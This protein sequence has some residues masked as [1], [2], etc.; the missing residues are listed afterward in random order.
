[1]NRLIALKHKQNDSLISNE[2]H[3]GYETANDE[4]MGSASASMYFS[5]NESD[6]S[7]DKTIE[8]EPAPQGTQMDAGKM[9]QRVLLVPLSDSTN[10]LLSPKRGIIN[11]NRSFT[12]SQ[13]S[14]ST[15]LK[16]TNDVEANADLDGIDEEEENSPNK[17]SFVTARKVIPKQISA[18]ITDVH[19]TDMVDVSSLPI[20]T[21]IKAASKTPT[22]EI[23]GIALMD[24]S[25]AT[26][27]E[28]TGAKT[29]DS[30]AIL[31]A[32]IALPESIT[33]PDAKPT[34]SLLKTNTK[35][36][37]VEVVPEKKPP[38]TRRSSLSAAFRRS[39]WAGAGAGLSTI[40][41]TGKTTTSL[42]FAHQ[43]N[44]VLSDR[45]CIKIT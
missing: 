15:P 40:D 18:N 20:D 33:S 28:L 36:T 8:A 3:D 26:G 14:T 35:S 29:V 13:S 42:H 11:G 38:M 16:R 2:T 5:M 45:L 1:M 19:D 10:L 25:L 37:Q 41:E 34:R 9:S 17:S 6:M 12:N 39:A 31:K 44:D 7:L 27:E 30:P 32:V 21:D 4:T 43:I 22:K 24:V 23:S